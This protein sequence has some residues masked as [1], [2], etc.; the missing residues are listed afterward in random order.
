[1]PSSQD[2]V[3]R[4]ITSDKAFRVL[5]IITTDTVRGALRAQDA[6]GPTALRLAELMTGAVLVREAM[7]P[8]RRVQILLKDKNGRTH[9]VADAHPTGWNRGIVNPGATQAVAPPDE[10]LL[11][12]LYTLPGDVLQQGIIALPR[13]SDVSTGLMTYMQDS[14][15]IVSMIAVRAIA[16]DS[17]EAGIKVAGGYMVQLLPGASH[18]AVRRMTDR[19]SAFAALDQALSAA[20]AS[21]DT[22]RQAVLG[23]ITTETMATTYLC[24]GCNC[25]RGR[26]LT[27][28]GTLPDA[29]LREMIAEGKALDIHCDACRKQYEVSVAD[30]EAIMARRHGQVPGSPAMRN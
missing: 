24:F 15:Q 20:D 28:L 16:D 2:T 12:V 23:D 19:L 21:A 7:S 9:M 3:V 14:E 4:T 10:M 22:L 25:D 13:D 27:G 1:M 11:E 17:A 5:T 18:D 29:D 26:V 30:L 8:E 6:R